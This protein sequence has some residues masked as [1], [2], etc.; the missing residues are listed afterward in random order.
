MKLT[1]TNLTCE[2]GERRVFSRLDFTVGTGELLVLKGPNG[3]GKTSLIRLIAGLIEP[4]EGELALE[5]G[6]TDL[7]LGQQCHLVAHLNA[8]KPTLTVHENLAFWSGF[9]G[10]GDVEPALTTF[11]LADLSGL[12]AALLSAGQ[13][14]RLNLARLALAP[15]PLWLLD[16]PTVGLDTASTERLVS[17]MQ[18]H[19][20]AGGMIVAATHIDLGMAATRELD[21]AALGGRA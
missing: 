11:G 1:G 2:R 3:T 14:R 17:L 5:G 12:S 20:G 19:M 9:L 15:R 13:Q 18:H 16:E 8:I 6:H 10:G 7:T 4:A 21:F